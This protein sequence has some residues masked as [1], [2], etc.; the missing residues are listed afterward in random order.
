[1]HVPT[2]WIK[3]FLG[4]AEGAGGCS[5]H[6][7]FLLF[8]VCLFVVVVVREARLREILWTQCAIAIVFT[9]R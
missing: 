7:R 5:A 6:M 1:V 4:Q 2:G 3:N 9:Q 8:A